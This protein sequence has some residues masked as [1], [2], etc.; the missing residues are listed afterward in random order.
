MI[1]LLDV[2]VLVALFDPGHLHHDAAHVWF[3]AVR[4]SGWAT[5]PITENGLA[6]VISN[7]A[8]PGRRTAVADAVARLA[9]FTRSGHHT[10]WPDDVSIL[11]VARFDASRL[12]GHREITDAYLIAL[13]VRRGGA[14]AT[15]DRSVRAAP[16][17]G[18]SPEH[19]VVLAGRD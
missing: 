4:A 13:A 11:D 17:A 16:V 12:E 7:P 1:H 14:L 3:A 2:N 15:F 9:R 10:R 19:L 6:R 5:C 18:F 8:Y